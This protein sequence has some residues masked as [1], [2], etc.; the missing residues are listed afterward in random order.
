DD[1][2]F[3]FNEA[4]DQRH[5]SA[6]HR[7]KPER[8]RHDALAGSLAGDPLH[9]EARSEGKLRPQTECQPEIELGDEDIV[10]ITAE[11]LTVLDQ[12]RFPSVPSGVAFL[13]RISHHTPNRSMMPIHSR[14]KK[15]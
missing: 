14:S 12:H 3:A 10:E 13:R 1:D 11:R 15:P 8:H 5:R 4:V 7:E 6:S 9:K 2:G